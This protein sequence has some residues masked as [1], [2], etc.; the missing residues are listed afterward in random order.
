MRRASL[1]TVGVLIAVVAIGVTAPNTAF[2][3]RSSVPSV[4]AG[5]ALWVREVPSGETGL[6]LA[7]TAA[8]A[9]VRTL[10]V[11]AGDGTSSEPQFSSALVGEI[12]SAGTT[13]CAWTFMYGASPTAEAAVAVA[14]VHEG[15]QCLVIDA[16]GTGEVP[17]PY[18]AA[19]LF[20]RTLRFQLGT[21]F[22]IGLAGQAE[23]SQHPTFPYSVF[24]GPGGCNVVLPLIYWLDFGQSVNAAYAATIGANSIY[25]RPILPV[26]QL[27]GAP[28]PAELVRFRGLAAAYGAPGL[29]FFDLD[30]ALPQQLTALTAPPAKLVRR[31]VIAPTL[32]PG[33]D[34][35]DIVQ[36]QEL[37]NAAGAHLPVG[38]FYG[39]ETARAVASFQ[40]RHHLKPDGILNPATWRTLL[41][42]RPLEPSWAKEPPDS[43][44]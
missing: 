29:S 3:A 24:L 15:A 12:R 20:V 16:G 5:T 38:G 13:V 23:V 27:Y 33:A 35:D 26:G 11:K 39:A 40:T 41:Q 30:S 44:K 8:G 34:G 9:G 2:A 1:A 42:F 28:T 4:F 14:A 17:N 43:A 18:G 31:A 19:Q 7:A 10:Y 32:R 25:G 6:E 21:A 22:P 37:L 36:A